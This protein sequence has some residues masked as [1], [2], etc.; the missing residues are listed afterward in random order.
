MADYFGED[1]FTTP[2]M[3]FCAVKRGA[4]GPSLLLQ[5]SQHKHLSMPLVCSAGLFAAPEQL[6]GKGSQDFS[7]PVV[8]ARWAVSA[9]ALNVYGLFVDSSATVVH[10]SRAAAPSMQPRVLSKHAA[11]PHIGC[12]CSSLLDSP[13]LDA[14]LNPS[15]CQQSQVVPDVT[16]DALELDLAGLEQHIHAAAAAAAD[17]ASSPSL[18][19]SADFDDLLQQQPSCSAHALSS[20]DGADSLAATAALLGSQQEAPLF[21]AAFEGP[22]PADSSAT[23]K[24]QQVPDVPQWVPIA[25]QQEQ[26]APAS[27]PAPA[28]ATAGFVW[29]CPQELRWLDTST[30]AAAT[31]FATVFPATPAA[32]TVAA[33]PAT[34]R[35]TSAGLPHAQAAMN[36]A[37]DSAGSGTAPA[38]RPTA[39]AAAKTRAGSRVQQLLGPA[40]RSR[41]EA[42]ARYKAKRAR[43]SSV[44]RVRYQCRKDYADQRHRVGGRFVKVKGVQQQPRQQQQQQQAQAQ[45]AF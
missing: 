14:M 19:W 9:A 3:N 28:S 33:A 32:A 30:L 44:S 1:S 20:F 11:P 45:L 29:P 13:W 16:P 23:H 2:V 34:S 12:C 8:G 4:I 10:V 24:Q 26:A 21:A 40:V 6:K 15:A 41:A 17:I 25:T 22:L 42:V 7:M 37:A 38:V 5:A 39:R 35:P 36:A 31:A 27:T 18:Q 43:R